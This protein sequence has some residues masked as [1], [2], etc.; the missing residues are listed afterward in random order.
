[1]VYL[2]FEAIT[3]SKDDSM[4][5][6]VIIIKN[7]NKKIII[8]DPETNTD[9]N[10]SLFSVGSKIKFIILKCGGRAAAT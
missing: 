7:K 1:M 3:F 2:T 9:N 4:T 5:Q 6:L 8:T 10:C